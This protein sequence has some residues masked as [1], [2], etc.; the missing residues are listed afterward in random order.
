M[1]TATAT[2]LDT[3]EGRPE[4]MSMP[5]LGMVLFIASEVMFFGGLFATYFNIRADNPV[6]PPPGLPH[7]HAT[8]PAIFTVVLVLSSV[9][10]H[11]AVLAIRRGNVKALTRWVGITLLLGVIFLVGQIYDYSTLEFTIR[12]GPYGSIFYVL[13]G[14]HGAHVF[15]GAMYL[16]IVF[17]RSMSG[18]FSKSHHAAVEGASMYWHFVD[19]VW[20]ALFF[21]L[22]VLG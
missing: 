11:M 2:D 14:F 16:F 4:G 3:H 1:T 17:I 20:I 15:G 7:L 5:L 18:Q 22:Y 19:I 10:M 6:W 8:I 21:T 13:T 12:D 9:T